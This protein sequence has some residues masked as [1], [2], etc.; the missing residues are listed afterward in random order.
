MS[1][2]NDLRERAI[3]KQNSIIHAIRTN[4]DQRKFFTE[5]YKD[6]LNKLITASGVFAGVTE[7][8]LASS[9]LQ[10]RWLTAL[11]LL[12]EVSCIILIFHTFKQN[13]LLSGK[14]LKHV[15][16]VDKKLNAFSFILTKFLRGE[17]PPEK[18]EE[19]WDAFDGSFE[20]MRNDDVF[21]E[22]EAEE[23]EWFNNMT[24]PRHEIN[25]AFILFTLGILLV[26]FSAL[27]PYF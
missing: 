9:A 26:A 15:K 4:N 7:A 27:L 11:G 1:N 8:L 10:I 19:K 2:T 12:L 5:A 13:L 3:K 18:L 6:Y 22:V 23:D 14:L 24:S 25:I 16:N 17:L 20:A 21:S